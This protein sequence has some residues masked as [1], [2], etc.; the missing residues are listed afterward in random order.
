V[1]AIKQGLMPAFWLTLAESAA[2][3]TAYFLRYGSQMA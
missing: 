1:I 2:V 3:P